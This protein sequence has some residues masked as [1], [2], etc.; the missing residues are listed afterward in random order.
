MDISALAPIIVAVAD[1]GPADDAVDW[2]AAEAAAQ[3]SPLRVVHAMMPTLSV[4]PYT[5][6]AF[7][8]C[9]AGT[10]SA[11]QRLLHNAVL[12][13][14]AVAP[15]LAVSATL[16]DGTV[17]W[18][19]RREARAARLLVMGNHARH[20]GLRALLAGSVSAALAGPAPCPVIVLRHPDGPVAG[21]ARVIVGVNQGRS[22]SAAVGFAF[23]AA[24]QRGIPLTL[25]H[26]C[27]SHS[28]PTGV[29]TIVDSG[30]FLD[31]LGKRT[32]V[33]AISRR[34]EEFPDVPVVLKLFL[35]EP[36]SVL[37]AESAGAAMLVVGSSGHGYRLGRLG[38]IGRTV[39]EN[40]GC[41][42]AIVRQDQA[43]AA[44]SEDA[45]RTE[46]NSAPQWARHAPNPSPTRSRTRK[47]G[48]P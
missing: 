2:A 48:A 13:A 22:C 38:S 40:A 27:R 19:V 14:R 28:G 46:I 11:G 17:P 3:G 25:V 29:E 16:L 7:T 30:T 39:L 9:T 15:E 21:A 1:A 36:A 45:R 26:G 10:R 34:F 4:D 32:A 12:R 23:R 6:D 8:V 31:A 24:W 35:G 44:P 37:I 43:M 41:P 47:P 5:A 33:R 20:T 42:T 18:A